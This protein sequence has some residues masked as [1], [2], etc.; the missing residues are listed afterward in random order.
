MKNNLKG[1]WFP[2]EWY[3]HHATW[4]SWPH[5]QLTWPNDINK[6]YPS[7]A[8]FIKTI[9]QGELVCINVV[10]RKMRMEAKE[11]LGDFG[12]M[13]PGLEIM[14]LHS[15][16]ITNLSSNCSCIGVT[17]PGEISIHHMIKMRQYLSI[18][19]RH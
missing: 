15:W 5:N 11:V 19:Q 6:I 1:F 18:S 8:Q 9:A 7:Y 10:D 4:L 13:M 3:P 14:A 12:L 2:P 16:S 17:M